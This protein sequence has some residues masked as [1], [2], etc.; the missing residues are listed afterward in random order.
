MKKYN[1]IFLLALL[2]SGVSM[3]QVD[4][5]Q[6]PKP[7]PTPTIEIKQ[8]KTF[9]LK[10]GMKVMLVEN[11]KL[12]HISAQLIIDNP[13]HGAQPAGV[14]SI[15]SGMMGNGTVNID[16]DSYNEEI[17]YLGA[18]ISFGNEYASASSLSKYFPRIFSLMAD[19]LKNPL[20]DQKEF[21]DQKARFIEGLKTS[22]KSVSA[23]GSRVNTALTYGKNHP[24]GEFTTIESAEKITLDDVKKYYKDY[25]KPNNAYLVVVGDITQKEL[26]KLANKEFKK[27]KNDVIPKANYTDP[28]DLT[29]TEINFIDMPNAVQSEVAIVNLVNLEKSDKD[30]FAVILANHILGGGF[31][32]MINLNLRED[33]GYTYGA[34]SGIGSGRNIQRFAATTQVRN[35][36]TDSAIVEVLKEIKTIRTTEV[37]EERLEMSKASYT[38]SFVMA[39][40]KPS[41][42]A[43]YALSIETENLDK[44]FYKNYLKNL[45]AVTVEDIQRVANKYFKLD[46]LRIV[47][48][49]KGSEVLEGL[50]NIKDNNGNLIPVR[51]F[52]TFANEVDEPVFE[53]ELPEGV[54]TQTVLNTYIEAIGGKEKIKDVNSISATAKGTVQGMAMT[55]KVITT[56]KGQ[57]LNSVH[58]M[59]MEMSKQVF[60]GEKG[61]AAGQGQ[62]MDFGSDQIDSLKKGTHVFPEL[63]YSDAKLNGI[64]LLD[65]KPAYVLQIDEQNK[66][67]YDQASGLKVKT[68]TTIEQMGQTFVQSVYL[69]DY[70]EVEGILLPFKTS[71]EIMGQELIFEVEEYKINDP[72]VNDSLFN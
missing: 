16:K 19:G 48:T 56:S 33:K 45:N 42:I 28:V 24:K 9:N 44:D 3:A 23:I 59:G 67:F 36:V 50:K 43:R 64:E 57:M 62:K 65:G 54:D 25:F 52:D 21:E 58:A 60:D 26:K 61:Y 17:D 31:N 6:M 7:G 66:I 29:K 18:N 10:N 47:I 11:H 53:I 12:P 5:S 37:T 70:K 55:N 35:A 15:L 1:F 69:R 32:G 46:Q 39:L 49:G 13:L 27:W 20:F 71:T 30:Y 34:Y 63:L 40:E 22:E 38:G 4:R 72:E 51:Y 41:T 14:S 2:I 8:P 68:E